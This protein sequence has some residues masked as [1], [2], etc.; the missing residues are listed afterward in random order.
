MV[1][2]FEGNIRSWN[3]E[4]GFGFI[5]PTQGGDDVFVHVSAFRAL[6]TRPLLKQ[7][8]SFE[9]ERGPNGKK[10]ACHVIGV[11]AVPVVARSRKRKVQ[12]QWGGASFFAAPAF[13]MLYF[14]LAVVWKVPHWVGIGFLLLSVVC[15]LAYAADK[16]AARAGG[17]RTRE[18]TLLLLGLLGGW[19]GALLAQQWLRHKSVKPSFR[20]AFWLTVVV[21]TVAFVLL[22]APGIGI[23]R[24]LH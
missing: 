6:G 19:P 2:R 15:F 10:R 8:V 7:R 16:F 5:A 23:W 11:Q 21:H 3:D 13:L 14:V 18:S 17:W 24:L 12:T 1:M 22:S 4:R 20:N 9:V